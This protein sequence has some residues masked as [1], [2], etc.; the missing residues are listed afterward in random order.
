MTRPSDVDWSAIGDKAVVALGLLL[1]TLVAWNALTSTLWR[2]LLEDLF[3]KAIAC[4][5]AGWALRELLSRK[6]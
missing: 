5:A 2:G 6:R 1:G 4:L 3:P